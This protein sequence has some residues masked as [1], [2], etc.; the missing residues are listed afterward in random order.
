MAGALGA[1]KPPPS[2]PASLFVLGFGTN[3]SPTSF[4]HAK[5][6]MVWLGNWIH[7]MCPSIRAWDWADN[8][9]NAPGLEGGCLIPLSPHFFMFQ[10]VAARLR[11][12]GVEKR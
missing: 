1:A 9:K 8:Y 2:F 5:S 6:G 4:C 3:L 11:G 10:P 12:Y 7:F